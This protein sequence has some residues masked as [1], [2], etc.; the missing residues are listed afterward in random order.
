MATASGSCCYVIRAWL[1]LLT[2]GYPAG[3]GQSMTSSEPD[4]YV[5]PLSE[6][7]NEVLSV[8]MSTRY[9]WAAY[10]SPDVI[11]AGTHV[12]LRIGPEEGRPGI[13]VVVDGEP[14]LAFAI[15]HAG[16]SPLEVREL[17]ITAKPGS[18]AF[19]GSLLRELP[20]IRIEAAINQ[21]RHHEVLSRQV[22][23][24]NAVLVDFPAKAVRWMT[25]PE[26]P[27]KTTRPDLRI[28][29]PGGYRKPD[30]FYRDVADR[31]LWLATVSSR[32]AQELAAAND[33]PAATVHR[34]I[35][36]AKAR[37]LL[38][39]PTHRSSRPPRTVVHMS[40]TK[41]EL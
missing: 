30:E 22:M 41:G 26:E 2:T 9:G 13:P 7:G 40:T 15:D 36:E 32:P 18:D 34:W 6:A 27:V 8:D 25:P 37:G 5:I 4:P 19:G 17:R 11:P 20:F 3:Y 23:P 29:D 38:L 10:F 35:R 28:E 31:Y 12:L 39:L 1:L 16:R 24:S 21:P 33:M 14:R